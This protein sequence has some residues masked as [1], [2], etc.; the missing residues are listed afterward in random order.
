MELW[1]GIITFEANNYEMELKKAPE[2]CLAR[3]NFSQTLKLGMVFGIIFACN[4]EFA[5]V[6]AVYS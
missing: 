3:E 1:R 6:I 2:T 4:K 5:D